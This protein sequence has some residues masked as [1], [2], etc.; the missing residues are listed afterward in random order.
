MPM[1]VVQAMV[2]VGLSIMKKV[3]LKFTIPLFQTIIS[4]QMISVEHIPNMV[5]SYAVIWVN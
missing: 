2:K 1:I 3:S 4:F 5:E